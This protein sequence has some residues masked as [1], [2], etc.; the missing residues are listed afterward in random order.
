[1]TKIRIL[2]AFI[3]YIFSNNAYATTLLEALAHTYETNP[4][5]A[6]ERE[7]LKKT[8]EQIYSAISGFLPSVNYEARESNIESDTKWINNKFSKQD[9]WSN[10]KTKKSSIN[11]EQNLFNGGKTFMAIKMAKYT[12]D[13]ERESFLSKEQEILLEAINAYLN[14]IYSNHKLEINKENVQ[15]YTKKYNHIKEKFDAGFSKQADLATALSRKSDAETNLAQASGEYIS[16]LAVYFQIT[17]LEAN[18]I[19]EEKNLCSIPSSQMELLQNS[20]KNNPELLRII[21]K[22]KAADLN[23]K[24]NLSSML[25]SIDLG[26]SLGKLQEGEQRPYANAKSIYV[27]VKVPIYNKGVEYSNVRS[28]KADAAKTKYELKNIKSLLSQKS[29]QLWSDFIVAKEMIKS[30]E[31]A[32]KSGTI[33]LESKQ[34][35]FN[36]GLASLSEVLDLQE[37]LFKYKLK[38]TESRKNLNLKVYSINALMGKLTAKELDIPT[39]LYD[40]KEN[41]NHIKYKAIGF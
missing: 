1:M 34:K 31:D 5:L 33:A 40:Y 26:A 8:D 12:I 9:G 32:V 37:N 4:N 6:S 7:K 35:E 16:N 38:L 13:A 14:I 23:I 39:K 21:F 29:T 20:L 30:S 15:A 41:Y 25:P 22:Q 28:S 11:L 18:N 17:G 36:E 10:I 24:Y 3:F 27:S 2:L 19:I